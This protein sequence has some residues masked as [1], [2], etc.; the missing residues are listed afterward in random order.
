MIVYKDGVSMEAFWVSH[1]C[2]L[3]TARA[4]PQLYHESIPS[5]CLASTRI[6]PHRTIHLIAKKRKTMQQNERK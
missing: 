4:R 5:F 3:C 1:R 2:C 6:K